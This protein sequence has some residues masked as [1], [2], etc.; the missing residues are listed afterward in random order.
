MT[1]D[2]SLWVNPNFPYPDHPDIPNP[3]PLTIGTHYTFQKEGVELA[4]H[5]HTEDKMH[6]TMVLTGS[7]KVTIGDVERIVRAGDLVDL[8]TK[9]HG[10]VA[11]EPSTILNINKPA[12]SKSADLAEVKQ[13]LSDA[14][15]AIVAIHTKL[16]DEETQAVQRAE[17]LSVATSPPPEAP[18]GLWTR[19]TAAAGKLIGK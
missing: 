9:P 8:D 13:S 2:K 11:L 15:A 5:S 18:P 16:D 3:I 6:C 19:M 4:T 12:A 1:L 10:F 17:L 7:L 14:Q